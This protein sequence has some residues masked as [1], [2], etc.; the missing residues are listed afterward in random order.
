MSSNSEVTV[1]QEVA[2][3]VVTRPHVVVLGAGASRA[4]F[5]NGDRNGKVLPLMNDFSRVLELEELLHQWGIDPLQNFEDTFSALYEQKQVDRVGVLQHRIDDYFRSLAPPDSPTLYDHLVLSLRSTDLIATFNWDPLLLA[6]YRRNVN[7]GL[8]LPKLAFLHGNVAVGY[9]SEHRTAGP[10]G[11][12]CRHCGVLYEGV[13]LLYPIGNKNYA[14][15]EFIENEWDQLKRGLKSAFMITIFGYSGP[16]TDQEAIAAMSEAWGSKWSREMEQTAFITKMTEEAIS[17][18]W[19]A[20]IHS[21]HFEVQENFYDSWIAYHP[22][23]T[24]EAWLNQYMDA[25]FIAENP[26]PSH[27][28]FPSLWNWYRQFSEAEREHSKKSG[29]D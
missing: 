5:P 22:R 29:A 19:D 24:G 21:H 27:Q 7:S 14:T 18:N 23:R 20:F 1:E 11:A 16:R 12:R 10:F 8:S 2:Q 9:C 13:P 3:V 6:A 26:V 25:K 4:A 15:N 28:D 17:E